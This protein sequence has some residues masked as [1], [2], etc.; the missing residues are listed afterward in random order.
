MANTLVS[1]RMGFRFIW[2]F[3]TL[4]GSR[5]QWEPVFQEGKIALL[6]AN[7]CFIRCNEEG[8]IEAKSKTAGDEEIIKIRTC[9]ER[10]AKQKDDI[11][12][13]DKGNVKQCE[14]NYKEIPDVFQDHA[15]SK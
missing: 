12:E 14:I 15:N 13:E 6:A 5:E 1:I 3:Q 9:A 4:I 7:S 10:E 11:P 2:A 8:D